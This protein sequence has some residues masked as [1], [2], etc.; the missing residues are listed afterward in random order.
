[1]KTD[2][3]LTAEAQSRVLDWAVRRR[4]SISL[5]M[6]RAAGWQVLRASFSKLDE[7]NGRLE[8]TLPATELDGGVEIAPGEELGVSF[9][10]GH[11]KCVFST[12]V[13][14]HRVSAGSDSVL[15]LAV[16][17]SMREFQRRA[18][19]REVIPAGWRIP[20]KLLIHGDNGTDSPFCTGQLKDIS[21]GGLQMELMA[22]EHPRMAIG[23]PVL[24]EIKLARNSPPLRLDAVYRHASAGPGRHVGLGLQFVGLEA[25]SA[26]RETLAA[27]ARFIAELRRPQFAHTTRTVRTN[28]D[29]TPAAHV[30]ITADIF[31]D[32]ELD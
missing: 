31:P 16:P 11:K 12:T 19:Q 14:E 2:A 25:S 1:M 23:A 7:R 28:S 13:V 8:V 20:V 24:I 22:D 3:N 27:L 15:L 10:R 30:D 6:R 32:G 29:A 4:E 26:G 9:R 5:S 17:E 21:A 18:Y